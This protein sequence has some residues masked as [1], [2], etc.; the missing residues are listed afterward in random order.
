[1]DDEVGDFQ[2]LAGRASASLQRL[3]VD[4]HGSCCSARIGAIWAK[5]SS[6]EIQ[7]WIRSPT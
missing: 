5:Y 3:A 2:A 1:L 7:L 4:E 6:S